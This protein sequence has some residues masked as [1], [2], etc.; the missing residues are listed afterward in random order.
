MGWVVKVFQLRSRMKKG[1]V[2]EP[3]AWQQCLEGMVGRQGL[4]R[5]TPPMSLV[6]A[7]V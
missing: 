1:A 2:L 5:G 7:A 4:S 6:M 3:E